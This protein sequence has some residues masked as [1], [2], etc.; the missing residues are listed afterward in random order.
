MQQRGSAE[1]VVLSQIENF[2]QGFPFIQLV[3]PATIGDG[4]LKLDTSTAAH[5]AAKYE[6]LLPKKRVVK[7]VPASGAASRMFK[8]L[9]GFMDSFDG[10]KKAIEEFETA[11]K[12]KPLRDFFTRIADFAFYPA[13]Q[14]A[15]QAD[16][17]SL[18]EGI[19][20]KEYG[21]V[22]AYLLTDKGLNY[23][24]LPKGLLDFHA[25]ENGTVR[26]PVEEH[27]VEGAAYGKDAEG[28]VNLHFTVSPE[29][30]ALFAEKVRSTVP[31]YEQT[32]GVQYNISFSNQKAATDTIAV[33][34][35]NQPFRNPDGSLLFRP[36]GHGAL[37][38][39]L[40]EI[41]ADLIF[42]K[43]I[44]NVVPDRL[45]EETYHYKKAL[46]GVLLECQEKAFE[47]AQ[48]VSVASAE[49]LEEILTFVKRYLGVGIPENFDT[50]DE[51]ERK[52]W[53]IDRL[54]RPMRV[55]GMVKNEGE[56]GGGPFWAQN[57]DGTVS[58]QIVESAQIDMVQSDQADI[59]QKA[60][61]FNPVDLVCA[62]RDAKGA[63]YD[64]LQY[65]DPKTGFITQKSK[66]GKEL[67]AQELPGLWNGAMAY[68][69]TIFV[70]V[71]IITFNP[72]KTVN[73]LLREQHQK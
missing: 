11:E 3:R 73:D 58:L 56:P 4:I 2:K 26:T 49:L 5:F 32:Y 30:D 6:Q 7:F 9:F 46:A 42:I 66:D 52:S 37:I 1:S 33:D 29:H 71:L 28:N 50:L 64:L 25:Y 38:E 44:D 69:N 31:T 57:S 22:L 63:K 43:N 36:A 60:T 70:E 55:C 65:R 15:A 54:N 59:V 13:L 21:K 20:H 51:A 16:G 8:A 17:Y 39:N 61:H 62:V 40:N 14:Q 24:S 72:V 12:L 27:M 41:E 67:K 23:G 19:A 34:M 45:K 68:W 35:D 18:E 47:Y 10:S 53:L 48:I